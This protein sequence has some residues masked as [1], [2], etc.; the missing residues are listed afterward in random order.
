MRE[1]DLQMKVVQDFERQALLIK[2]EEEVSKK[3]GD[4]QMYLKLIHG[5]IE[6]DLIILREV[7]QTNHTAK[8]TN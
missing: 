8:Q 1:F 5:K 2:E 3:Q 7:F 6:Q 4:E